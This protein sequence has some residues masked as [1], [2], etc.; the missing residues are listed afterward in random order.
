MA[1]VMHSENHGKD[2]VYFYIGQVKIAEIVYLP[3]GKKWKY[4]LR[5]MH[6][7][8]AYDIKNHYETFSDALKDLHR[9]LNS[10]PPEK[11]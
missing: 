5:L 2:G 11:N 8:V 10:P 6:N 4:L 3:N 1:W 9:M 7:F